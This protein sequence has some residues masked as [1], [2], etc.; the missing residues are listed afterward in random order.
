MITS[1]IQS[2]PFYR[3]M[4]STVILDVSNI[5]ITV[6]IITTNNIYRYISLTLTLST[7]VFF[8]GFQ[9]DNGY[10]STNQH[11]TSSKIND[12]YYFFR[13]ILALS[14]SFSLHFTQ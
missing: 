9:A 3:C 12:C 2:Y 13:R 1:S 11:Q 8:R 10:S 14:D 7:R 6:M 4:E 5:T